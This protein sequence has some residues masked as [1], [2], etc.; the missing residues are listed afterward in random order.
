MSLPTDPILAANSAQNAIPGLPE[1]GDNGEFVNPIIPS[2]GPQPPNVTGSLLDNQSNPFSSLTPSQPPDVSGPLLDNQSNPFSSLTPQLPGTGTQQAAAQSA[3]NSV[4]GTQ[5]RPNTL[6]TPRPTSFVGQ[7]PFFLNAVLST[8]AGALPKQPLW[9]L[10]FDF[11][12]N[13]KNTIKRVKQYEPRMPEPWLIDDALNTVTSR[14]YQE[15]KGCMFAQTVIVPGDSLN[16]SQEG[17]TYNSFIRGGVATGRREFDTLRIGF[18]NTNVSFVD[19]VIRPW[20]VMTGHL[21]MI[22][23]PLS[24]KYRCNLTIYKLG[25]IRRDLPPFI[26]QQFNFWEV[27]PI[28]VFAETLDYSNNGTNLIKDAEFAYQW[29]TTTSYK[30][31]I[32]SKNGQFTDTVPTG[33][34]TIARAVDPNAPVEVRLPLPVNAPG[35]FD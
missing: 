1:Y 26:A 31:P 21:G 23:R 34:N 15:E 25:I 11:D 17:I 29:Y 20:V 2:L 18:L 9:I 27:C 35:P 13:I 30:S 28:N 8:P 14:R 22:A 33:G 19:N 4:P 7:I 24:Q 32:V 3:Q 6:E 5:N 16:Y 12:S 10:V